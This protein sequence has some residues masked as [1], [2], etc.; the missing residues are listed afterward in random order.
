MH[1]ETLWGG[2]AHSGEGTSPQCSVGDADLLANSSGT[3]QWPLHRA[4]SVVVPALGA[5]A[6]GKEVKNQG[7]VPAT[8]L[9]PAPTL[10]SSV[11]SSLMCQALCIYLSHLHTL[12][13][14]GET[15]IIIII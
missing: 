11:L 3:L 7:W 14:G 5:R 6:H 9:P 15:A 10:G 13:S 12:R 4:S 2:A 8:L 1:L